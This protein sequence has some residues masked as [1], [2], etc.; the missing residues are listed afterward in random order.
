MIFLDTN[1]WKT[2]FLKKMN[3]GKWQLD[4]EVDILV[5]EKPVLSPKMPRRE[6]RVVTRRRITEKLRN[7]RRPTTAE[8]REQAATAV[9]TTLGNLQSAA[10]SDKPF[11]QPDY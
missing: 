9:Q 4:S 8:S 5:L 2:G 7:G 10:S 3:I 6:T 11:S 1:D